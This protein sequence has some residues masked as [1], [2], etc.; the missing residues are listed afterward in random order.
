VEEYA[1]NLGSLWDTVEAF[2][3]SPGVH[4]G[5]VDAELLARGIRNPNAVQL[6]AA[7]DVSSE[8]VK[9]ALLVSGA[10]RSKYGKLKDELANNYL[11]GTDQYPDT[12][13]KAQRILSNYQ[14]TKMAAP[15]R[16][17]RNDTGVAFLQRGGGRG[18]Q[19]AGRGG[20][21]GRGSGGSKT[22]GSG[23]KES[24]ASDD[25]STLTG[26]TGGDTAKTNSRG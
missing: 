20:Q 6:Q 10:S 24:G 11:L 23:T 25:V 13:E 14:N 18:G 16:A 8:Q 5:L 21:D 22:E 12:Y 7:E 19:A 9:A 3:G 17:S 26:R 1:R 15:Y 2:G 4:H